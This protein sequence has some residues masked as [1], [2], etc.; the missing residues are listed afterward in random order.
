MSAG[1]FIRGIYET[2]AGQFARIRVQPETELASAG[3]VVND[4]AAGPV[5]LPVAAKVSRGNREIGILPRRI[6]IVFELGEAPTGYKT[7]SVY[8]VPALTPEFYNACVVDNDMT[9][10]GSTAK[11][12]SKL[13]ENIR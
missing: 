7:D 12:V 5:N 10:L 4:S 3:G 13:E 8:Y 6:G 9:Y 2:N 1:A 11:I